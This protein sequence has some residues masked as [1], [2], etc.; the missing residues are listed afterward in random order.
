M[1]Y[2]HFSQLLYGNVETL[3]LKVLDEGSL[4]AYGIKKL[5]YI[6][7]NGYL[8]LTEARLYPLLRQLE[9]SHYISSKQVKSDTGRIVREYSITQAGRGDLS[10]QLNAWKIFVRKMNLVLDS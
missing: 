1:E 6:R 8:G 5:L 3:V 2:N 10:I 9:N 4:H 7:T